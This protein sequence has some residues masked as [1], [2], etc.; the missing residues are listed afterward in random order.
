M[1]MLSDQL[2]DLSVRAKHAEDAVTAAQNEA[3]EKIIA[4]REKARTASAPAS[5]AGSCCARANESAA[6]THWPPRL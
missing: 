1:A 6:S 5:A 4:R 3:H 2:A